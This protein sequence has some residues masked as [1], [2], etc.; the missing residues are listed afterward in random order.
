MRAVVATVVVIGLFVAPA[1]FGPTSRWEVHLTSSVSLD[2]MPGGFYFAVGLL[3]MP[4]LGRVS[5]RKRDVL[6][7]GLVPFYGQ[8]LVGKVVRRLM[9]LPRRD[10]PPSVDERPRA[11]PILGS[12]GVYVLPDTFAAAEDLR[13]RWCVNP[14]HRHPYESWEAAQ[15]YGC[16]HRP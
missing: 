10:W 9:A 15:K 4:F 12:P 8:F 14:E 1:A 6:I 5:Y 3:L 16:T 13:S 2:P 11:V 7:I